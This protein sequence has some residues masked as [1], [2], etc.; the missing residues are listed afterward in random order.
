MEV[1]ASPP[2]EDDEKNNMGKKPKPFYEG[3]TDYTEAK[4]TG[5]RT[6]GKWIIKETLG[7]G[8]YSWVKRGVDKTTQ[9]SY[10]LKFMERRI[11]KKTKRVVG[12]QI[13]QVET[14]IESL[15]NIRHQ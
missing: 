7:K 11:D 14:E 4:D 8:G 5:I 9:R 6:L 2:P 1:T 10:A 15:K 12:S 3:N 13:K